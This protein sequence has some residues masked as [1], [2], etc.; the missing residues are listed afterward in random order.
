M[1]NYKTKQ[2]KCQTFSVLKN[3]INGSFITSFS[4]WMTVPLKLNY[5]PTIFYKD[6]EGNTGF[7]FGSKCKHFLFNSDGNNKRFEISGEY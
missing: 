7:H 5:V 2:L 6:I 1:N 4:I 3:H